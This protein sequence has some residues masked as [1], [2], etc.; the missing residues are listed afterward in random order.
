MWPSNFLPNWDSRSAKS[1]GALGLGAERSKK[2]APVPSGAQVAALMTVAVCSRV[3]AEWPAWA[4]LA[5]AAIN[6]AASSRQAIHT[7]EPPRSKAE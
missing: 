6:P 5:K 7:P 1:L 4:V 2:Y 3:T